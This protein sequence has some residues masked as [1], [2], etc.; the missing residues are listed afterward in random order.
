MFRK[1][2]RGRR[3]W[4]SGVQ[5]NGTAG[6]GIWHFKTLEVCSLTHTGFGK[7]KALYVILNIMI[8]KD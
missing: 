6:D 3:F 4:A 5:E 1:M 8:F 2:A 7:H